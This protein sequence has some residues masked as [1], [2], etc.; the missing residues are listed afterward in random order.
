[1]PG[2]G[3]DAQ[4]D[5]QIE[6]PAFLGQIGGGE[7]DGDAARRKS[8]WQFWQ[9]GAHPIFAFLD[10]GFRQTDDGEIGRPLARCTSTVT[11]AASMPERGALYSTAR[12]TQ[13]SLNR[14]GN[15]PMALT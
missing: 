13:A 1:L 9:R 11:S 2:R 15:T 8:N 5:G 3:E 12:L 6:A 7:V 10:L 14:Y 4:C